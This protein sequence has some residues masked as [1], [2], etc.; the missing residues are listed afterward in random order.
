M[1]KKIIAFFL[2]LLFLPITS[3]SMSKS[4]IIPT[5]QKNE[6]KESEIKKTLTDVPKWNITVDDDGGADYYKIQDAINNASDGDTIFVYNGTYK[7]NLNINKS[8]NLI[9]ENKYETI[10]D[11]NF[12]EDVIVISTDYVTIKE[13]TI[14]NGGQNQD[15]INQ[16]FDCV[17]EVRSKNNVI[18]NNIFNW[19][20]GI[21]PGLVGNRV[22]IYTLNY[23]DNNI[24]SNNYFMGTRETISISSSNNNIYNN[25]IEMIG[26]CGVFLDSKDP[27][28][29]ICSNNNISNNIIFNLTFK[30]TGYGIWCRRSINNIF[31]NNTIY[32]VAYGCIFEFTDY[33]K[34]I[35]NNFSRNLKTG[36]LIGTCKNNIVMN[37]IISENGVAINFIQRSIKNII[38]RNNITHNKKG[39]FIAQS[40]RNQFLENNF[41]ENKRDVQASGLSY[42]NRW[43]RNYW[44]NKIFK[45]TPKIMIAR[46]GFFIPLFKFDLRP[47]REPYDIDSYVF[48]IT[49]MLS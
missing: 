34:V 36:L 4:I 18:S 28:E 41:I 17:I 32:D 44:D 12:T 49:E 42:F 8:I 3:V 43:R 13:F 7:E 14:K 40:Y 23:C 48:D 21:V 38:Q 6:Q 9:G 24:I 27:D 19:D 22:G 1:N 39:I 47:A 45:L 31:F 5:I 35:G 33:N 37:N 10:I 30:E 11:G 29:S 15:F 46:I 2:V 26:G 25:I 20:R 16:F